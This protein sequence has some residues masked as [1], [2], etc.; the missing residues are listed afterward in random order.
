MD[1][2]SDKGYYILNVY[3]KLKEKDPKWEQIEVLLA[4]LEDMIK[5]WEAEQ[6]FTKECSDL[7]VEIVNK[8]R[9]AILQRDQTISIDMS[10][11]Y[12]FEKFMSVK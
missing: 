5:K 8:F 9:N 1:K 4:V 10:H 11:I 6:C 2:I 3:N 12:S 7:C